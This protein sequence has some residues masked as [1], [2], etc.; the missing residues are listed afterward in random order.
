MFSDPF[1]KH[2]RGACVCNFLSPVTFNSAFVP[3]EGRK[4]LWVCIAGR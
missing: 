3:A 4:Y 2:Q 1:F